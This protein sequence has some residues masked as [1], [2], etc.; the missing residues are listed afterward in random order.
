[1]PLFWQIAREWEII[2][3]QDTGTKLKSHCLHSIYNSYEIRMTKILIF[4]FKNDYFFKT[5]FL[6]LHHDSDKIQRQIMHQS[7]LLVLTIQ[8][9][10]LKSN[11]HSRNCKIKKK[12][13]KSTFDCAI[14]IRGNHHRL[15][16]GKAGIFIYCLVAKFPLFG[17]LPEN[18]RFA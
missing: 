6:H 15:I 7:I 1:L 2:I 10:G 18:S 8:K 4:Y 17:E 13:K 11:F 9:M 3:N 16:C 14:L 5:A 12:S